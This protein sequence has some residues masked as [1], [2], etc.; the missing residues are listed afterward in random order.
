MISAAKLSNH[1][2]ATT[3]ASTQEIKAISKYDGVNPSSE[4]MLNTNI[5]S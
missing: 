3:A 4:D 1:T 5:T 2:E